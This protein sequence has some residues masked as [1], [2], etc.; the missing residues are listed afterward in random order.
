M[1]AVAASRTWGACRLLVGSLALALLSWSSIAGSLPEV[2]GVRFGVDGQRTR[3]VVDLDRAVAFSATAENDPPRLVVDLPEVVWRPPRPDPS[4]QLDGLAKAYRHDTPEPGRARLIV[5]ARAPLRV[6][7][8]F[9]LEPAAAAPH[10]RLVVDIEALGLPTTPRLSI[11]PPNPK[12]ARR[13]HDDT[14]V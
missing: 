12:P 9:A 14:I 3:I 4:T 1:P 13:K 11:G 6:V 5:D 10:Y 7:R 2:A 8:R